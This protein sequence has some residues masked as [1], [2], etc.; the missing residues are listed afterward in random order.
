MNL[1]YEVGIQMLNYVHF[2]IPEKL[3]TIIRKC[4]NSWKESNRDFVLCESAGVSESVSELDRMRG[5]NNL[6]QIMIEK[7]TIVSANIFYE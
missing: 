2:K 4:L 1:I 5:R 7:K 3:Q 6:L